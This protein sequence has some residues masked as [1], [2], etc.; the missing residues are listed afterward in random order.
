LLKNEGA[1]S[2]WTRALSIYLDTTELLLLP[3]ID[4]W[5]SEFSRPPPARWAICILL[6]NGPEYL[7]R[8][9]LY[10]SVPTAYAEVMEAVRETDIIVTHPITFAAQ[11]AAVRRL[12]CRAVLLV[13]PNFLRQPLAPGTVAFPY[14]PYSKIFPRASVIVHSGGIG[15]CAQ[16]LAAGRP[17]LVV[18]FA[19]DQ[20]DNA[21][22]LKRLGLARAVP[23]RHYTAQ[24]AYA[25]LEH[26]LKDP[27]YAASAAVAARKIANENGVK[28]ACDAID[29]HPLVH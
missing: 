4:P 6:K 10:P 7:V 14:A 17:M 13:G 27:A 3:S 5:P 23:R 21:A 18:P 8:H 28:A 16:A 11:I 9:I 25:E 19:F 22:R 29:R 2:T 15:T 20:P 24:R 1:P 26:L 12:A